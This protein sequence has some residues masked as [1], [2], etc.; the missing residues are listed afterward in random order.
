MKTFARFKTEVW[1]MD[2]AYVCN[3]AKDIRGV[4]FL[5]VL[6]D[7]FRRTVDAEGMKTKESKETIRAF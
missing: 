7:L 6:Q 2:L 3:L 1:C 5:L 4:I